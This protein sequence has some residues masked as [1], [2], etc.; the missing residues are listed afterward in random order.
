M[1]LASRGVE[2]VIALGRYNHTSAHPGLAEHAHGG[3]IEIC[4]LVK[5]LQTYRLGAC[6]YRLTGG[7]VFIAFPD[8]KHST[9]GNPQEKGELYWMTLSASPPS[10]RLLGLPDKQGRAVLRSL[11]GIGKHH[12][13]GS[14]RMKD[15]LDAITTLYHQKPSAL[16]NFA[17][18]NHAGTFLLEVLACAKSGVGRALPRSLVPVLDHIERHLDEPMPVS[19]LAS[20]AGLSEARFKARF[21]AETGIPPGEFVL[22]SR[23]QE[24]QRRLAERDHPVTRVAFDLGFSTSQYFATVFKRFTGQTPSELRRSLQTFR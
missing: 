20:L 5:G 2:G 14:W 1:K 21:K 24:A 9:G 23:I 6:D 19:Q 4:F 8:E 12:F 16:T 11:L 3:A 15:S 22:R 18:S 13:R 7:D 17:M 10:G